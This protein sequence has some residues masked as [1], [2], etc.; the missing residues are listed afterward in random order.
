MEHLDYL[1][2][3]AQDDVAVLLKKEATYK[4]SWKRRGGV[5]AFMMLAR[6]WDRLEGIISRLGRFGGG[7]QDASPYDVF[8][9]IDRESA[10]EMRGRYGALG[11][12]RDGSALAEVRDLRRYLLLVEAEMISRGAVPPTIDHPLA[13]LVPG[14][15]ATSDLPRSL[16]LV[17]DS[18]RHAAQPEPEPA[19]FE[20]L[21]AE[22]LERAYAGASRSPS[23]PSEPE[24]PAPIPMGA[25]EDQ[26]GITVAE[27][28]GSSLPRRV[29]HIGAS[30]EDATASG[31]VWSIVDRNLV[32]EEERLLHLPR[33]TRELNTKELE[34][35]V[36]YYR[37]MYR[38]DAGRQ[39]HQLKPV[40]ARWGGTGH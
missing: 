17:E 19:T 34:D 36:P 18:N 6:K 2:G 14:V 16:G 1:L 37:H 4:G 13:D 27:A 20:K 32:E 29:V 21:K 35:L 12:G 22:E 26:D 28:G 40:Y 31:Q 25:A 38:W 3:I 39:T 5:G 8:A 9:W 10:T 15:N 23:Q 33:L 7:E 11:V 30:L 24:R